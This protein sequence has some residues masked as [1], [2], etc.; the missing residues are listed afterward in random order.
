MKKLLLALTLAFVITGCAHDKVIDGKNYE[1]Y[2]LIDEPTMK[3]DSIQYKVVTGNVVWGVFLFETV[4]VPIWL[5]GYDLYEP[6]E[7]KVVVDGK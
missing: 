1:P 5:F 2:G 3:C 4:V 7:K 6:V